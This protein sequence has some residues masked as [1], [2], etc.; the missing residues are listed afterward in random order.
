MRSR[1]GLL[2]LGVILVGQVVAWAAEVPVAVSP[3]SPTGA[4]IES[5]CPTFSWGAV[6]GARSYELVVYRVGEEG[7]E[8][9]AVMR[10]SFPA[11]VY[12][13]TPSLG[14]CL[15]RGGRY[16]WSVRAAGSKGASEWS[17]PS[18]FE[19]ASGPSV[20]ELEAAL[21]VV[22]AYARRRTAEAGVSGAAAYVPPIGVGPGASPSGASDVASAR[23]ALGRSHEGTGSAIIVDGVPVETKAD[24]PCWPSEGDPDEDHRFINCG[25]GTVLDTVT[26]L[27]WLEWANCR[28]CFPPVVPC[29]VEDGE[30]TWWQASALAA[31]LRDGMCLL[32][33]HSQKGDWR[34]PT[35]EDWFEIVDPGCTSAPRIAGKTGECY[36]DPSNTWALEVVT[37]GVYH[38]SESVRFN[39][40]T[41]WGAAFAGGDVL[42]L[43]KF[44]PFYFWPVRGG[45]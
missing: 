7:E 28:S 26:G 20:E 43:A 33:D 37:F 15:E 24:P 6:A 14:R 22:G 38:G 39:L 31:N 44:F 12:S 13:W 21:E 5:R 11:A 16:A 32:S 25:N 18:L 10:Q 45:Q 30:R 3:G 40:S 9:E 27:L 2:A 29:P 4:A 36:G 41:V 42:E 8:P 17:A 19:V 23:T 34:L 35:R 1:V